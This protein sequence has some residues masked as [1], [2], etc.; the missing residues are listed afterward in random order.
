ME[1]KIG[2][3]AHFKGFT[4]KFT[5]E[6]R[7]LLKEIHRNLALLTCILCNKITKLYV[8]PR[9]KLTS[10]EKWSKTTYSRKRSGTHRRTT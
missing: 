10:H 4:D 8:W 6:I 1:T 7:D 3:D 9:K 2:N 5:G